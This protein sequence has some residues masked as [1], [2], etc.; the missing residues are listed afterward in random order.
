MVIS[1]WEIY[2]HHQWRGWE[3]MDVVPATDMTLR[4]ATNAAKDMANNLKYLNELDQ[5]PKTQVVPGLSE[6]AA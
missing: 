4:Q 1:T 3:L 2:M 6:V 5:A